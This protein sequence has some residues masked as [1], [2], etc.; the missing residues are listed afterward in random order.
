MERITRKN[1]DGVGETLA[2]VAALHGVDSSRWF[3]RPGSQTYGRGWYLAETPE[4]TTGEHHIAYL[5][6]SARE[7]HVALSAMI[8]AFDLMHFTGQTL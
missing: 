4:G 2:R 6:W 5:G 3:I 1:V 8:K 7:A